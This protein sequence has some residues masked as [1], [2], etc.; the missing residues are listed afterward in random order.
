MFPAASA[1][2]ISDYVSAFLTINE[3]G[4]RRRRRS[5]S[6]VLRLEPIDPVVAGVSRTN[7]QTVANGPPDRWSRGRAATG[8]TASQSSE[9]YARCR[10][11]TGRGRAGDP[12]ALT[13][14]ADARHVYE[15]VAV[16][17][18]TGRRTNGRGVVGGTKKIGCQPERK[19][20]P[21]C[22]NRQIYQ[23]FGEPNVREL[24]P[25]GPFRE[26]NRG[27]ATSR[28]TLAREDAAALSSQTVS[29]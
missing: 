17:Q 24:E 26:A 25:L 15:R 5:P 11:P 23:E 13:N 8:G 2:H 10:R 7:L 27:S 1:V 20:N 12:R 29:K 14:L 28:I 6:A 16:A 9:G 22:E 3:N 21:A 4:L 19:Q 18:P